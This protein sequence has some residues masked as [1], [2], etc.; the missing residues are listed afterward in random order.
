MAR[1]EKFDYLAATLPFV[2]PPGKARL[3]EL[4]DALQKMEDEGWWLVSAQQAL[5]SDVFIILAKRPRR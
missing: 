2:V 5:Q 4:E 1:A 3:H